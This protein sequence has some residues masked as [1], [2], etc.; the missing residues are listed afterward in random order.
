MK[1]KNRIIIW[2]L[3]FL[4]IVIFLYYVYQIKT[5]EGARSNDEFAEEVDGGVDE[6]AEEVDGGVDE[7]AEEVDGGVDEVDG[8]AEVEDELAGDNEPKGYEY[9]AR[10]NKGKEIEKSVSTV[11]DPGNVTG[12]NIPM[13]KTNNKS[14]SSILSDLE[15]DYDGAIPK[16][17]AEIKKMSNVNN[18]LS[19][20]LTDLKR[21][22]LVQ[23]SSPYNNSNSEEQKE[24]P[25]TSNV[26]LAKTI[27]VPD[28]ANPTDPSK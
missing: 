27:L 24:K 18:K 9:T 23:N 5:I 13:S 19:A 2:A 20:D 28:A 15:K 22:V 4:A 7:L 10:T 26:K 21:S 1:N 3:L 8:L 25:K 11:S 17:N 14:V 16:I 6:L 12:E